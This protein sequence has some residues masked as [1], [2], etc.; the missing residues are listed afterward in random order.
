MG[1]QP[2]SI[3]KV[4]HALSERSAD[5]MS[6]QPKVTPVPDGKGCRTCHYAYEVHVGAGLGLAQ[7]RRYP[8]QGR[9]VE[10]V[11]VGGWPWIPT[12]PDAGEQWCG[13]WKKRGPVKRAPKP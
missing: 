12:S 3:D 5:A 9:T 2:E 1:L 4:T 11:F 7:C 6:D 8:P 13:E 10:G